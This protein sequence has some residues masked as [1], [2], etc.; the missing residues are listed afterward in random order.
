MYFYNLTLKQ[1]TAI[2]HAVVGQ[3]SGKR[4]D[5]KKGIFEIAVAK[6]KYL[7]IL[8]QDETTGRL[9]SLISVNVFGIIRSIAAF[10]LTGGIK[11]YL[12]IGSES[13]RLVILEYLPDKR[14][15]DKVHQETFGRSGIRRIVPGQYLTCDSK[16]RAIM[17]GS[18]EKQK[19]VYQLN[20]D[21]QANLTISSPLEANKANTFVFYMV[22]VDVGYENPMFAC[23]EVDYE[24]ADE[25]VTGQA[26]L[27]TKQ[28]LTY[29]I[30]DLGLNW[31]AR[32]HSEYLEDFANMLISVPGG[33]DGPS[34]LLVCS[35]NYI[36]YK[37]FG[38]QKNVRCPI[39]RRKGETDI[40]ERGIL[41]ACSTTCKYLDGDKKKFFFL[42]QTEL[43]DVFKTD[44][45]MGDHRA[46]VKEIKMMYFDTLPVA[47]SLCLLP[48]SRH[49]IEG[50][51]LF[52]AAESGDHKL[53]QI[54]QVDDPKEKV[55]SSIEYLKQ[56]E[57]GMDD[58]EKIF[59][60]KPHDELRNMI[61]IH[62]IQSMAPILSSKT[63]NQLDDHQLIVSCGSNKNS[64]LRVL[65]HGLRVDE[66]NAEPTILP[67]VATGLWSVKKRCDSRY[68]EYI[69]VSFSN[70]TLVLGVVSPTPD[71]KI[72]DEIVDSGFLGTK[73]TI[74]CCQLGDDSL[75]QVHPDGIRHIHA[76]K[77][78][79]EWRTPFKRQIVKCALNQRQVAVAMSN[80]EILYF[81]MDA[82]G[83][84]NEYNEKIE[85]PSP[86]SCMA[87]GEIPTGALRSQFLAVGTD[88]KVCILNLDLSECMTEI[89]RQTFTSQ[90][91]SLSITELGGYCQSNRNDLNHISQLYLNMGLQ[92]GELIRTTLDRVTGD[93]GESVRRYL[94]ARTVKLFNVKVQEKHSL[95]ACTNKTWLIYYHQSRCHLSP[96]THE[97]FDHATSFDSP[98]VPEG[99]VAI[100]GNK[101]K[102]LSFEKLGDVYNQEITPLEAS[103]RQFV[104]HPTS[105]N[106]V[107]MM[108]DRLPLLIPDKN[109]VMEDENF[110][111]DRWRSQIKLINPSTGQVYHEINYESN[112]AALSLAQATFSS[113]AAT[114][115]AGA[116]TV[117]VGVAMN[118]NLKSQISHLNEIHTYC[119]SNNGEELRL[120]HKTSCE[121]IPRV[122]CSF[123]ERLAVGMGKTLR[124]YDLGK[125][126]LLRKCENKQIPN[127]IATISAISDRLY[128][129]DVQESFTCMKYRKEE[130][131]L[132]VFADDTYPRYLVSSSIIDY[133]T[134]IGGDKFGNICVLQLPADCNDD[135]DDDPSGTKSLW[136]RGWLGGSSQKLENLA[137]FHLGEIVTS[138]QKTTLTLGR[139]ECLLYTT[140]FGSIGVLVE[141]KSKSDFE[142]FQT[143]EMHIRNEEPP[144]CGRDH[145]AF[146]SSFFPIKSVID[147]DLCDRY[148]ELDGKKQSKIADEMDKRAVE[149]CA[150][151]DQMIEKI[152]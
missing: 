110:T 94:G 75:V 100:T 41:I 27:E 82:T 39:P 81:E 93:L 32:K 38:D 44:L 66:L 146:S 113:S 150:Q 13:G 140:I 112:E 84:L 80:H 24:E 123:Q 3:F 20:R 19:L 89:V 149:I 26:A 56:K 104:I 95:L 92:N 142:F 4:E 76:D 21:T 134:V 102:I 68:D 118:Y 62:E 115:T 152:I 53:Y 6:G 37:N 148:L 72:I 31:V 114:A 145:L 143:L 57:A 36:T 98:L 9:Q 87:I 96:L 91:E 120:L 109:G 135:L 85:F 25:D 117:H 63:F 28:A 147:G 99:V 138:I 126:K 136:D 131:V 125:K 107:V 59:Q 33:D 71:T 42:I 23:L 70:A 73:S 61:T 12:A 97:P 67:S 133:N 139:A 77:R 124:I 43:G 106:I 30:L 129:C 50:S 8:K 116:I 14:R 7:E 128:V 69:V 108:T 74:G 47:T 11:D 1:A 122:M 15:F 48:Q 119:I 86:V 127:M 45:V 132:S 18:V 22:N 16:G 5:F 144:L 55:F 151:I 141:F 90:P 137:T 51:S 58:D 54:Q 34:G 10:R 121:A 17:I 40:V 79:S 88:N 60:F 35:K 46:I 111:S 65:K 105:G 49:R 83:Q 64:S 103:P 52:V 2:T 101:L 78:V 29:Y 130:N